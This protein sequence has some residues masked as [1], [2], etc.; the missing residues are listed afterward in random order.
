LASA[1]RT[2]SAKNRDDR[3]PTNFFDHKSEFF[4]PK[5]LYFS[6]SPSSSPEKEITSLQKEQITPQI[7]QKI[8]LF[9]LGSG[10]ENNK[11]V[12]KQMFVFNV[13]GRFLP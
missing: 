3:P 11:K 12:C 7:P 1:L 4:D 13:K 8:R 10:H 9:F 5:P 6:L 2:T